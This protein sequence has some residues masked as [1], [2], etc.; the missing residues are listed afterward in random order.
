MII[1][2]WD[3]FVVVV[4]KKAFIRKFCN[5]EFPC[6]YRSIKSLDEKRTFHY[7]AK[8]KIMSNRQWLGEKK[9]RCIEFFETVII[10]IDFII[11][12]II[13]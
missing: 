8:Y 11:I 1:I 4:V 12:I 7:S 3:V 13:T 10:V 6:Q 2:A 5:V 9:T